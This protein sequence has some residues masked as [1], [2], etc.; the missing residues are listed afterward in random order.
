[1]ATACELPQDLTAEQHNYDFDLLVIG[2]GPAGHNAAIEAAKTGLRVAVVDKNFELGGVCLH[3]G[4]IPSKT[5][6]EAVLFLSGFRQRSFY[7]RGYRVKAK[8]QI[9]DLMFRVQEVIKRQYA[10]IQDQLMRHCITVL[11]GHA[12]FCDEPHTVEV[13]STKGEATRHTARYF[14][15]C[16][17]TRPA[18]R[19]DI[20]FEAPQVYDSDEFIQVTEGEFPKSVIVVGAGVIGLEYASMAAALG[21]EVTVVE[22]R[23]TLLQHVDAEITAALVYQLRR[24]GVTFRMGEKVVSVE[25]PDSLPLKAIAKLES[26]KTLV[27]EALLYAIG[28]QPNTDRLNLPAVGI[29]TTE[30]GQITVNEF[31]Q[32]KVPHIY[33]AG[34]I[35]GFP[36]LA[37]TS[38]E[39]GRI[40]ACHMFH[41]HKISRPELLPFGIYTIPEISMVGKNEAQLTQEKVPYEVGIAPFDELAKAQISGDQSGLLKLIFHAD[42]LQILGVHILGDGASELVHIGQMLMMTGG[43]VEVLRDMVFNY[44]SLGEAYRVAAS[45]GLDKLRRRD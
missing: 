40:A 19:P 26:G 14:L 18:R 21:S 32:T 22:A 4:T 3:T 41:M 1:M 27:A 28:R 23:D 13:T 43:T 8:I 37:S 11:D 31:L 16:C 20:P 9:E 6:R 24:V 29:D 25:A 36:S 15:I 44:P 38:M 12:Q 10:V 35:V 39:Q 2:S 30:R 17:G 45:N 5:L 34:D 42:T 7:G 33:A